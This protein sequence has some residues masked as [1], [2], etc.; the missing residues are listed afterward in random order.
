[1]NDS[2][3]LDLSR[4]DARLHHSEDTK[5][6]QGHDTSI[7][8]QLLNDSK[9]PEI[10]D[11]SSQ[12]LSDSSS[13]VSSHGSPGSSPVVLSEF[14]SDYSK[15]LIYLTKVSDFLNDKNSSVKYLEVSS[16]CFPQLCSK[17]IKEF[18][19]TEKTVYF[20]ICFICV[21]VMFLS[22]EYF[23]L[24]YIVSQSDFYFKSSY[25]YEAISSDSYSYS[26][27]YEGYQFILGYLIRHLG[28]FLYVTWSLS[29]LFFMIY[30][31][32]KSF[33]EES[34]VSQITCLYI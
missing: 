32:M 16:D 22:V 34:E 20:W 14:P 27:G 12:R 26:E 5:S 17:C 2:E 25:E 1:M 4:N 19:D 10:S 23:I 13:K 31:Y 28:H 33:S 3:C 29:I 9:T 30:F 7:T 24:R 8:V 21:I 18:S 6:L 11:I 15:N